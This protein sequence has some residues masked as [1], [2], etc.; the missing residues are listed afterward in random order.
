MQSR[1]HSHAEAIANV[2]IGGLV[3]WLL[4]IW[5]F[6]VS[7][8]FA[9]GACF[10]YAAASYLRSY[11]L[12]RFFNCY[13]TILWNI[14]HR[15]PSAYTEGPMVLM[16]KRFVARTFCAARSLSSRLGVWCMTAWRFF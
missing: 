15:V 11:L 3:S 9:L 10:I 2:L 8:N 13:P 4:T 6:R 12:R 5:I 14:R 7:P 16:C 1:K